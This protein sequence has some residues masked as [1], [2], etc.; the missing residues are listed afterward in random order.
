LD[1]YYEVRGWT[2]EGIPTVD[3]LKEL[4]LDELV[5]IVKEKLGT[6]PPKKKGKGGK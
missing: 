1:D 5:P 6:V 4:G 2:K 3:K